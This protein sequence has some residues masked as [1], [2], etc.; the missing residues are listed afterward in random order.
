MQDGIPSIQVMDCHSS[1]KLGNGGEAI[2]LESHN[3]RAKRFKEKTVQN[4]LAS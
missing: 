1:K 3:A 2:I 4:N